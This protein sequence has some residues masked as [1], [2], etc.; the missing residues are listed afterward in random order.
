MRPFSQNDIEAELSYAYL[1]AVAAHA[2]VAC[3]P[4]DRHEDGRGIDAQLTAWG[5][6]PDSYRTEVNLKVQ[7]KA[8]SLACADDG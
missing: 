6:W 1:H 3:R 2:G 7:L 8:T 4:G 5:N